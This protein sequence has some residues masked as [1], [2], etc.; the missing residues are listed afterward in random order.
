MGLPSTTKFIQQLEKLI[1]H[2]KSHLEI[3]GIA[4]VVLLSI[5]SV[6]QQHNKYLAYLLS[7]ERTRPGEH[8]HEV[9]KHEGVGACIELNEVHSVVLNKLSNTLIF[10]IAT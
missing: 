5:V 3:V 9:R 8:I 6:L 10:I 2:Q 4:A 7:D 1:L